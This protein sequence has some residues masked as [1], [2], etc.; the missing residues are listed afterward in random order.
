LALGNGTIR[1]GSFMRG[2]LRRGISE[3]ADPGSKTI[4]DHKSQGSE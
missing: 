1:F 3:L 2:P 4:R